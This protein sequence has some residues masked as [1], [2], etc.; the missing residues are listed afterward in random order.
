MFISGLSIPLV[1]MSVFMSV[2][3]CFDYCC[4]VGGFDIRKCEIS[5]FV[6]FEDYSGYSGPMRFHMNL[7]IDFSMCILAFFSAV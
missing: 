6:L 7:G 2:P 5:N 4:F 1:Y 3:H